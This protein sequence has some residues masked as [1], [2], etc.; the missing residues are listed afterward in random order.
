MTYE[1]DRRPSATNPPAFQPHKGGR[2]R[3][4]TTLPDV[5]LPPLAWMEHHAR[6]NGVMI[7]LPGWERLSP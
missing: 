5:M 1:L 6:V 4:R 2:L 7:V 3:V